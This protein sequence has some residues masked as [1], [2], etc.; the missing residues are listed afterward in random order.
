MD[1]T[2]ITSPI[3]RFEPLMKISFKFNTSQ[4]I[5]YGILKRSSMYAKNMDTPLINKK[6]DYIFSQR[7]F[8]TGSYDYNEVVR[9]FNDIPKFELFRLT[10][11]E[12]LDMVDFI[13]AITNPNHIQCYKRYQPKT[14]QL[15]LYFVIPYYLFNPTT[16]QVITDTICQNLDIDVFESLPISAPEKCRLHL[17][18]KLNKAPNLPDEEHIERLLTPQVQPWE[19]QVLQ[20]ILDQC[21]D[22]L[23]QYPNI[24]TQIPSHYK[25][26]TQPESAMRDIQRLVSL[27][28]DHPIHFECFSFDYPTTS[29]LA[30][31]VSM[32]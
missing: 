3:Q 26:R 7:R 28:D 29:D 8:L 23:T 30:G 14:K 12:L 21:P 4:T 27:T 6:M 2:T 20:H 10:R 13:M 16:V 9:I 19:D 25:V 11:E 5:F 1:R 17:H 31:K 32:L 15:K 24:I 18:F 22:M